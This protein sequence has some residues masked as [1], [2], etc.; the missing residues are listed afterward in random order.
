MADLHSLVVLAQRLA[1]GRMQHPSNAAFGQWVNDNG[2]GHLTHRDRAALLRIATLDPEEASAAILA[3]RYTT[4][5][6]LWYRALTALVPVR[7]T[8]EPDAELEARIEDFLQRLMD[9][10]PAYP[11]WLWWFDNH[12]AAVAGAI[13]YQTANP[14][15]VFEAW[16]EE[17]RLLD[18]NEDDYALLRTL[19]SD[20]GL[21]DAVM[22]KMG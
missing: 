12:V 6:H 4:P 16:L 3:S 19:I 7:K 18:L 9:G 20:R 13:D 5:E 21:W 22:R 1:E 17:Q 11:D 15:R 8:L 10:D 14:A 2:L